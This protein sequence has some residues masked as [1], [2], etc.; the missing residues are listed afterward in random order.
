[1]E[2]VI[3]GEQRQRGICPCCGAA[4]DEEIE[5]GAKDY[6]INYDR[7][8]VALVYTCPECNHDVEECFT[9]SYFKS[10]AYEIELN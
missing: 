5:S 2:K 3:Y 9:M 4:L 6:S 10:Q 7:E 8:I 1:M